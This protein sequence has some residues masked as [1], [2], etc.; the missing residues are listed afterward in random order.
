MA[1]VADDEGGEHEE[2]T[3]HGEGSG[4]AHRLWG[5]GEA[6]REEGLGA[7]LVPLTSPL[8]PLRW[9]RPF[10]TLRDSTLRPGH[11]SFDLTC[12]YW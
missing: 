6:E 2:E 12:P 5:R 10:L 3:D 8:L 7:P 4:C 11:A 1:D 9:P